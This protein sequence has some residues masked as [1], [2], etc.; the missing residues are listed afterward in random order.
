RVTDLQP[1]AVV[2][3]LARLR[4]VGKSIKT[5][6]EY[7]AAAKGFSRWLWRDRR[8]AVDPLACLSKL[9]HAAADVRHARRDFLPDELRWLLDTTKSSARPFR[10][11]NGLD[12]YTI[13]LTAAAS[14]F[15][16]SELA[17]MTP[18]SFDLHGDTPTATVQA[19]CTKNR[20]LAVQPL[21][22][23]VAA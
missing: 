18:E 22:L 9:A 17:S 19:A 12:R 3:F 15:R 13:Y 7:L 2:E 6:N 21:P 16:P 8:I 11:L 10:K 4:D 23:E 1:S 14:G 5:A 20:K